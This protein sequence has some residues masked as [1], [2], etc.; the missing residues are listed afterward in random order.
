MA[1]FMRNDAAIFLVTPT[2]FYSTIL[3]KIGDGRIEKSCFRFIRE[4]IFEF[5]SLG[6]NKLAA[7]HA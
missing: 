2:L 4:H 1:A 6:Y 5:L 7:F 3:T